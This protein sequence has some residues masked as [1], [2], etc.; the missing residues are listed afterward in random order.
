MKSITE[1][2]RIG[3]GPSSSHTMG[4]EKAANLFLKEY[5]DADGYR[6]RLYG[7]LCLT[8][9]GHGTDRVIRQVF[10]DRPLRVEF[11]EH[12]DI[13]LKHPNTMDLTAYRENE[14][15]GF[16][17]VRS[18][19]G[20]EIEIE[21]K[22][23]FASEECY[24]QQNFAQIVSY[25][26]K[27][28]LTLPQFARRFDRPELYGH[29]D[30]VWKVMKRAVAEGIRTEGILPGGLNVC[31]KAPML[32]RGSVANER[33]A[34]YESR[35]LSAYA[36][37]VSEQNAAGGVIVTAPT[38]GASG[39][40]PAVLL[41]AQESGGYRDEEILDALAA[42]GII[43]NVIK[44]NASISGAECGCQAEIGSAC[45]MAAAALA[46]LHHYSFRQLEYA[47][48][49]AMEHYIGLTCD[50]VC[51]LVQIP[52]IE[53]NSVAAQRAVHAAMLAGV[54][55]GTQK[56]SFDCIV[57]NMYETG[58][59]LLSAYR[60]TSVGGLAKLYGKNTGC[61]SGG[62]GRQSVENGTAGSQ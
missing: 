61:M 8:G 17:L 55:S 21:G 15:I 34:M 37:A 33:A 19:G 22:P 2:Y 13:P 9:K 51:G 4:P 49:N 25:C 35:I 14:Q 62:I 11:A 48:E 44:S 7:S 39:V 47:A 38:C 32:Y 23:A 41:Q 18:V 60:E 16:W 42:A 28:R 24:P 30:E 57:S 52:C 59:D 43:G 31:R 45:C 53:R 50:P 12:S 54:L 26:K 46:Q 20:G 6:V 36:F 56:V 5:P 1:I 3:R 27:H 10:A 29:L 58:K 40:L